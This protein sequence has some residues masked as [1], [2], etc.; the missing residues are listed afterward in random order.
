M[1][2][3]NGLRVLSFESRRAKEIAHLI[4]NSGGVPIVAPSTR[5][6]PEK[7]GA[8]ELHLIQG[9][10]RG[11]FAAIIFMTGVGARALIDAGI[12]ASLREQ[13]LTALGKIHA[14]VRGPK[15]AAIMREFGVP[16]ALT[17]PE[18]NTWSEILR[19]LDA[20]RE[21]IPLRG[22]KVAVQEHG[23]PSPELYAALR[24]RGAEVYPVHVYAWALPEDTGP[25]KSAIQS[26]VRREIDI[27][28]F[29]ASVQF[30]HA[31]RV[32]REMGVQKAFLET[33]QHSVVASI[34][35]TTSQTLHEHGVHVDFEPSHP[36]MG[37]LVAEIAEQSAALLK[38]KSGKA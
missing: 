19:V 8:E 17:V 26:V 28:L 5:D 30:T 1:T 20:N 2:G 6:V 3:F 12:N 9:I 25:L 4:S 15:P 10:L 33:L 36:R 18:P 13:F 27:V 23:E 37:I 32:A 16:I 14:V 21:S 34:G 11:E 22:K 7:P 38:K 31:E 24:E 29:T 35:P